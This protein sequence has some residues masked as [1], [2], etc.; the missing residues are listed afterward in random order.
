MT[1]PD[2]PSSSKLDEVARRIAESKAYKFYLNTGYY[3]KD[4]VKTDYYRQAKTEVELLLKEALVAEDE[5]F[6][7]YFSDKGVQMF[8]D[9]RIKQHKEV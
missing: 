4:S 6:K 2:P 9:A 5:V 3:L 7:K 8:A 1:Q